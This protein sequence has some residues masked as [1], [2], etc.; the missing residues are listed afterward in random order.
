MKKY[1]FLL[2]IIISIFT[3]GCGDS[4]RT[5]LEECLK[6]TGDKFKGGTHRSG[7]AYGEAYIE[8]AENG[9]SGYA[10]FNALDYSGEED[11]EISNIELKEGGPDNT[12]KI[13][14]DWIVD[15]AKEQCA[16]FCF[17][18]FED[19]IPNTIL[20]QITGAKNSW[21]HYKNITLSKEKYLQIKKILTYDKSK[22]S[23]NIDVK[24]ENNKTLVFSDGS[25]VYSIEVKGLNAK[26][27]YTY[28]TYKSTEV[29][30]LINNKINVSIDGQ[31]ADNIYII[32]GN[33]LGVYNPENDLYDYYDF[34]R[35]NSNCD[36][37]SIFK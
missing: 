19:E 37:K 1:S 18:C 29:A 22:D 33:K 16:R 35:K 4:A 14:G 13:V 26:I 7:E 32:E 6:I 21:A 10:S 12:Y 2:L 8:I 28:S 5:K 36:L 17:C 9:K 15:G 34:D 30:N 24:K 27:N 3:V 25:A 23:K 11:A 20:I 31:S